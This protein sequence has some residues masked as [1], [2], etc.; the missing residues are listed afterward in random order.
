MF[1]CSA[2]SRRHPRRHYNFG[3]H[4]GSYFLTD[5]FPTPDDLLFFL[6]HSSP[7]ITIEQNLN[8]TLFIYRLT[9]GRMAGTIGI[10]QRNQVRKENLTTEVRDGFMIEVEE[11]EELTLTPELCVIARRTNKG[12]SIITAL[13]GGY[14]RP[15]AQKGQPAEEYELNKQF[16]EEHVLVKLKS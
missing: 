6:G 8:T 11:V 7:V 12:L 3:I 13:P 5:T 1:L 10:A 9:D 14:A 4:A 15:F 2:R 16:W